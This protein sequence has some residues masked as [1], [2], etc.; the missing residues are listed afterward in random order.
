MIKSQALATPIVSLRAHSI[1]RRPYLQI[2]FIDE[3]GGGPGVR[4]RKKH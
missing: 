2:A 4:L 3:N 1:L